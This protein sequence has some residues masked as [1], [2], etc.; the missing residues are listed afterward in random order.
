MNGPLKYEHLQL[1]SRACDQN[2]LDNDTV[3]GCPS[4]VGKAVSWQVK[5]TSHKARQMKK[6]TWAARKDLSRK[7]SKVDVFCVSPPKLRI[8]YEVEIRGSILIA[9]VWYIEES[10]AIIHLCDIELVSELSKLEYS[11]LRWTKNYFRALVPS[12]FMTMY[13]WPVNRFSPVRQTV[14]LEHNHIKY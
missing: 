14:S 9:D 3:V 10:S 1:K 6:M 4:Q 5:I 12:G 8:E 2:I 7:M 13:V 11:K